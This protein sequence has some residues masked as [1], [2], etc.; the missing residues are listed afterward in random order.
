LDYYLKQRPA[1]PI[2]LEIFDSEGKLVRRFASDEVL[3]HRDPRELNYPAIWLKEPQ[4]LSAEAGMH[5]FVWDLRYPEQGRSRAPRGESTGII[6]LPGNYIVKLTANGKSSTM[7]LIVK[8]D[9]HVKTTQ[10]ALVRQFELATRLARRLGEVSTAM[11]EAGELRKKVDARRQDAAGNAQLLQSLDDFASKIEAP[12]ERGRETDFGLFGLALPDKDH[13]PLP[14]VSHA[15][16]GLLTIVE[17]AD[18]A[19]SDDAQTASASWEMAAADAL[20]RWNTLQ[21]EDLPRINAL[22]ETAKLK[23]LT[24]GNKPTAR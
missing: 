9:P 10:D 13:E 14:R 21:K 16:T 23:P 18:V 1:G 4:P 19:P 5:R 12:P 15:L 24:V 2:Q 8:M 6:A 3:P 17:S 20:G 22:L 11:Y 7:P